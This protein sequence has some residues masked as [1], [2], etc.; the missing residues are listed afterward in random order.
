MYSPLRS[1]QV[2]LQERKRLP[3]L[4]R[5]RTLLNGQLRKGSG[6]PEAD[7]VALLTPSERELMTEPVSP[8]PALKHLQLCRV[9]MRP[10]P[11]LPLH[12]Q[13][14]A[15][16]LREER[17]AFAGQESRF[18]AARETLDTLVMELEKAGEIPVKGTEAVWG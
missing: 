1:V 15:R 7:A 9:F 18:L 12:L 14:M 4:N 6:T 2:F 11:L 3:V 16:L 8:V 17:F 10:I 13:E 5:Y